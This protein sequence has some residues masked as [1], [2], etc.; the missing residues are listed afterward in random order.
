MTGGEPRN[1]GLWARIE[2]ADGHF[3]PETSTSGADYDASLWRLQAGL[4]MLITENADGTLIGGVNVFYGSIDS[5]VESPS[6]TGSIDSDGYGVGGTLT[7]YGNTG[8]YVDGQAQATW[9]DSDIASDQ[10][11]ALIE[12]NDGTGYGL[13]IEA[14]KKIAIGTSATVMCFTARSASVLRGEGNG[15]LPAMRRVGGLLAIRDF[16][17]GLPLR[18]R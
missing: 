15:K 3:E 7:W 13:S 1:S 11:G 2:G 8:F 4:D 16:L 9:Y 12:G 17:A 18:P 10:L 14:G 6:G 5:D